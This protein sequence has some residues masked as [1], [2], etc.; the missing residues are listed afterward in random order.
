[1]STTKFKFLEERPLQSAEEFSNS[2]FGHGE[3]ADTLAKIVKACPAPFT[4]GLFAKWGSGKSTVANSLKEKLPKENIPVII[5]DVWKHEG[6]ALRRTFLKEAER[7]LKEFGDKFFDK[8]FILDERI[9]RKVSTDSE[10]GFKFREGMLIQL[11]W[12]III[13]IALIG[14]LP[15]I[16]DKLG[17]V[18]FLQYFFP[19]LFG[20][21]TAGGLLL[22]LVKQSLKLFTTEKVSFSV[23]K[24]S[25]PHQF[26]K[27][28][29][30]ILCALKNPRILIIFDNLDRVMHDKVAEVLSTIKTFLEPQDIENKN[31]EVVFLVPCDANAIKQ[32]LSS[33]YNP[34]DKVSGKHAFDPDEFLRKFFNTIVWIPDFIIGELESFASSKLRETE[35][36]LLDNYFVAW[37]IVK[38]FRNNPRQII[39]FTNILLA[40]YLLVEEREGEGE[41]KDFPTGFLKEN[42]PQLTKYLVLNQLFPSEMDILRERKIFNLNDVEKASLGTKTEKEF[43]NFVEQ[44]KNIQIANLLT[45][46]T[47]RRS[48]QEKKFPGFESFVA[49]LEDRAV[50]DATK[51]FDQLGDLSQSNIAADFSQV[52]KETLENKMN[53]VSTVN[54]IHTL[55]SILAKKKVTLA[56]TLYEDINQVLNARCKEEI[57]T[58]PPGIL[59]DAFLSKQS[60]YR[61]S[62]VNQWIKVIEDVATGANKYKSD[63]DFVK[64]V[65]TIVANQPTYLDTNQNNKI[66]DIL[67][68]NLSND[69]AI[70]KITTVSST[71]QASLL[72]AEYVKNFITAVPVGGSIDDV[73]SR[74]EVINIFEDTLLNFVEADFLLGKFTELQTAENLNTKPES[75]AEKARLLNQ[76]RNFM[77]KHSTVFTSAGDTI[78]DAFADS[79]NAGFNVSPDHETKA[80]FI[81]ILFKVRVLVTDSK[82]GEIDRH[83]SK[84]IG[85][86]TPEAFDVALDKLTEK[87]RSTFFDTSIYTAGA[88]R[89]ISDVAFREKFFSRLSDIRKKEFLEQLLNTDFDR[90]IEFFESLGSKDV[91]HFF[92]ISGNVWGKYDSLTPVQKQR[93]FK[94]INKYK[95]NGEVATRDILASKIVACLT[96]LDHTLQQIGFEAL[97]DA[98]PHI[99]KELRRMIVKSSF[100]WLS[101]PETSLKYQ[102]HTI[103]AIVSQPDQFNH[104]EQSQLVH[105]IFDDIVRKSSKQT[106]I[107]EAFDFLKALKPKYEERTQNF[108]DIKSRIEKEE[109][110]DLKK[111]LIDGLYMLK[112]SKTN[113]DNEDFWTWS[114]SQKSV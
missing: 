112:P 61:P 30:R 49:L 38:A 101:K 34:A 102:P 83:V 46:F 100:D 25:D 65:L 21:I 113:K 68:K 80:I 89:A 31:R 54:L 14:V 28:F 66:K 33:V 105:L 15:Y 72:N 52:I 86:V 114:N 17:Y 69:L 40:N 44:T 75:F 24:F 103:R 27:E 87:D 2:K 98:S 23:D 36:L 90:A 42:I 32:H 45:F 95:A 97:G 7:Q 35:V 94:F 82:K 50:E 6:D 78:K 56:G 18:D 47:L 5:F 11:A 4:V 106:H 109:N 51:Y 55:L 20:S 70:A 85:N 16:A 91:K 110:A 92:A 81:P 107:T 37:I 84:F 13:G 88:N 73:S 59:N 58:I 19:S 96:N 77:D 104:E 62:I 111:V 53:P 76:F 26:E 74:M 93:L 8:N 63:R 71:T 99:S 10:T 41:N 79:L 29:G 64:A 9:E 67:A 60:I 39:Q 1:M 12:P 48:E 43:V 57:H 22:W 108:N 3:I